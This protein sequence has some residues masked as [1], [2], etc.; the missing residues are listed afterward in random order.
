MTKDYY[1]ILGVEKSATKE[2]IKKAYKK[3]A[4]KYHPDLNKEPNAG[5]KFKEINEAASILADDEKRSTYDQFG[6]TAEGFQGN[7]GF[8][9][10]NMG[11]HNFDFDSIFNSF[12]EGSNFGDIFGQRRGKRRYSNGADLRYDLE[13]TLEEAAEGTTK[14]IQIPHTVKCNECKGTGARSEDDIVSCSEC[15]GS[16]FVRRTARTPFGMFSTQSACP[17]CRGQGAVIKAACPKCHGEGSIQKTTKLEIKIPAG[18]E[19]GTNLRIKGAGEAGERSAEPGDLYL[20][21]HVREHELFERHGNDIYIEAPITFAHAALGG[22]IEVPTLKGKA[23]LV[24]PAG[25]QTGT[26]FKMK[27]KG[28]PSLHGYG[29]GSQLVKVIIQTPK[30]LSSKQK[31][32]LKEFDKTL[33]KK[34][35]FDKF[36]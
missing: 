26:V 28:I 25:T 16:G 34:S 14:T 30:S 10:S 15:N 32:L 31:E 23:E 8:D 3:L 33:D 20:I 35:F 11:E 1:K 2:E 29:T 36:F 5:E 19:T 13:I 24:I 9:F 7:S 18:S 22:K 4:K 21:I 12:F 27:G 17:K 6:T